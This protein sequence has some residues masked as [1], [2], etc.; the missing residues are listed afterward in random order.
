MP[1]MRHLQGHR[2]VCQR[3]RTQEFRGLGLRLPNTSCC[4]LASYEFGVPGPRQPPWLNRREPTGL[5]AIDAWHR[6]AVDDRR[7]YVSAWPAL[8]LPHQFYPTF[9]TTDALNDTTTSAA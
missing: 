3:H 1:D 9:G 6:D 8:E 5:S 4:R 2:R 7:I